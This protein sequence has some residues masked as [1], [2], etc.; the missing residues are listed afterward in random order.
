MI[1]TSNYSLEYIQITIQR[2]V[3]CST[4]IIFPTHDDSVNLIFTKI[5]IVIGLLIS[6]ISFNAIV[7]SFI[8][9]KVVMNWLII[10]LAV[11]YLSSAESN[12]TDKIWPKPTF[13]SH[14]P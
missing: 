10:L 11:L 4:I 7:N 2:Y 6:I 13:F 12:S 5:K 14:D 3:T 1:N 8:T 9:F